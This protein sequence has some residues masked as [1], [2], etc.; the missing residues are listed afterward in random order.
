M[1]GDRERIRAGGDTDDS[2]KPIE[3]DTVV[4]QVRRHLIQVTRKS[5]RRA[6]CQSN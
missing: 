2:E 4:G 3:P 6:P 1:L 5:A